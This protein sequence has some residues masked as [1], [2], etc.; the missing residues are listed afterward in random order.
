MRICER[1]VR[2]YRLVADGRLVYRAATMAAVRAYQAKR[3]RAYFV[4]GAKAP[5]Y[6]VYFV[7]R[8]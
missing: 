8:R 2:E 4:A 5:A 7:T 1:R 3:I 6:R